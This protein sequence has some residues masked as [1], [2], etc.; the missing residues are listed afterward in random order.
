MSHYLPTKIKNNVLHD[1]TSFSPGLR[2]VAMV[3]S[4][5]SFAAGTLVPTTR[6][7]DMKSFT[8]GQAPKVRARLF[9]MVMKKRYEIPW[10]FRPCTE[11]AGA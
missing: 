5:C 9:M 11:G 10:A 8:E 2:P 1:V 6:S 7:I 4:T 3:R